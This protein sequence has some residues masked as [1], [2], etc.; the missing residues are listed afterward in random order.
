MKSIFKEYSDRKKLKGID[1][2][3]LTPVRLQNFETGENGIITV[4]IPRF[5]WKPMHDLMVKNG[6]DPDFRLDLDETGSEV[7][8][9]IDGKKKVRE[10]GEELK[11]KLGEKIE[12]D[13]RLVKFFSMMYY[14]KIITFKELEN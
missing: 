2:L 6:R 9:S 12:P 8:K 7:W 1:A 13:A 11:Q 3:E 14:N 10:I 5:K 4:L